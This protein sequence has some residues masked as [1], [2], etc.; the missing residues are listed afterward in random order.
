MKL[1]HEEA[2]IV[3]RY[4]RG[5]GSSAPRSKLAAIAESQLRARAEELMAKAETEPHY[6]RASAAIVALVRMGQEPAARACIANY[7]GARL[8]DVRDS[9]LAA[10]AD[11]LESELSRQ[12]E[13]KARATRTITNVRMG[14]G[15]GVKYLYS[16]GGIRFEPMAR[17][18]AA[19]IVDAWNA[20][21]KEGDRRGLDRKDVS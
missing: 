13:A 19:R 12:Q 1:T 3:A 9:N 17:L 16:D 11:M 5:R 2:L 15:S 10:C 14:I 18:E 7:G 4:G 21:L 6:D 8:A 20:G